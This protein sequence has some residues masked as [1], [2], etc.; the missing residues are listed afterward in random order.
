MPTTEKDRRVVPKIWTTKYALTTGITVLGPATIEGSM[1]M[2]VQP[3]R[4][5][6]F[7]HGKDFHLS[8]EDA[9]A[10]AEQMRR[11]KLGRLQ[12]QI[13]KLRAKSIAVYSPYHT[14]E[15]SQ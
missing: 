8:L 4:M 1:A 2:F 10:R 11:E 15:E 3:D 12:A 13:E 9:L 5:M 14:D 6:Q 7:F